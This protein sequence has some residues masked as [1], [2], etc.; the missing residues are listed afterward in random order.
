MESRRNSL[1][2]LDLRLSDQSASQLDGFDFELSDSLLD[3]VDG[4]AD[5]MLVDDAVVSNS[6]FSGMDFRFE[7]LTASMSEMNFDPDELVGGVE[8]GEGIDPLELWM[9]SAE[10]VAITTAMNCSDGDGASSRRESRT[11]RLSSP[12]SKRFDLMTSSINFDPPF[13]STSKPRRV[14]EYD[15]EEDYDTIRNNP[16]NFQGGPVT[17]DQYHEALEKLA[18]SMKRTEESRRQVMIQ[19][20]LMNAHRECQES[21]SMARRA[22]ALSCCG[23]GGEGQS[24]GLSAIQVF[25]QMNQFN[26]NGQLADSMSQSQVNHISSQEQEL[27]TQPSTIAAFLTGKRSTL[28][29]GLE[30]SR[31]QLRMYMGQVNQQTL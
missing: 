20:E 26:S 12:L 5:C 17:P 10:T 22:S 24:S 2:L 4:I 21:A 27:T 3:C 28:T 1:E 8:A 7:S 19:R 18:Q 30:Q 9:E 25:R 23:E 11:D 13:S 6:T 15:E 29:T 31:R 16:S 14:S